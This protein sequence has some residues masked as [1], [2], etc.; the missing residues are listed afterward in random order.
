LKL[1]ASSLRLATCLLAGLAAQVWWGGDREST[2][3]LHGFLVVVFAALSLSLL[4]LEILRGRTVRIPARLEFGF[5]FALILWVFAKA[6]FEPVPEIALRTA[7]GTAAACALGLVFAGD[8]ARNPAKGWMVAFL[9]AVHFGCLLQ[10]RGTGTTDDAGIVGQLGVTATLLV[11]AMAAC[12]AWFLLKRTRRGPGTSVVLAWIA[13]GTLL[14]PLALAIRGNVWADPLFLALLMSLLLVP[15][16]LDP[17]PPAEHMVHVSYE[18]RFASIE[19]FGFGTRRLLAVGITSRLPRLVAASLAAGA[20]FLG[21]TASLR[22]F[23]PVWSEWHFR[24]ASA[25]LADNGFRSPD[26]MRIEHHLARSLATDPHNERART[27]LSDL[28]S[29]LVSE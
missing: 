5:L 27:L 16:W 23:E 22:A 6:P 21:A 9:V 24:Q 3:K 13:L 2:F 11:T 28:Q 4:A 10:W 17:A 20:V 12:A 25:L 15:A 7:F 14:A 26:R 8:A 1:T 19:I 18:Y 29:Y